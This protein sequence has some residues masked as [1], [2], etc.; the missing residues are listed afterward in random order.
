MLMFGDQKHVTCK[1]P[2]ERKDQS[3]K[4]LGLVFVKKIAEARN[5]SWTGV[6][7]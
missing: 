1:W 7:N 5:E 2:F 6:I 4:I 3:I